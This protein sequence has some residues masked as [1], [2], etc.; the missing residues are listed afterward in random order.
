M[1]VHTPQDHFAELWA[2][3]YRTICPITPPLC[4]LYERSSLNSRLKGGED[5]RGK[6]PGARL[7]DGRWI[8][9][10]YI[11]H[12]TQECELAKWRAMEAGAGIVCT[13]DI[14]GID[15]D[16]LQE[17]HAIIV[18][19]EIKALIGE[20]P[21]RVGRHPKGLYVV[22]VIGP[23]PYQMFEFGAPRADGKRDRVEILANKQFV[24]FGEHPGTRKPY[25]WPKALLPYDDLP[26][27]EASVLAELMQRLAALLPDSGK[28]TTEKTKSAEEVDQNS[29][30]GDPE[31]VRRALAALPNT[32]GMF[33]SRE[34]YLKMGYRLKASLPDNEALAFDL[35]S[36]WSADWEGPEGAV[37]DP[38]IVA[39][40]WRRMKPP[41]RTGAP[42]LYSMAAKA[43]GGDLFIEDWFEE[44]SGENQGIPQDSPKKP[45]DSGELEL[46]VASSLA[47]LPVPPQKWLVK[48]II[49]ADNVTL[50]GG[51]GGT[52]KSLLALQLAEAVALGGTWLAMP[53]EQGV[54]LY[55]SA[56]DEIDELHRR[57]KIIS[58]DMWSLSNL[59]FAPLAG[60]DA[61]LA[62]PAGKEGLLKETALFERLRKTIARLRP[63]VMILDTLADLFGG[64]E[65]KKI[66]ARS[67]V[68]MLRGLA[69][70]FEITVILLFHPSVNGMASGS[71]TSGNVGWSNSVR[72]RLYL[73][74]LKNNDG[75]EN[76]SN[77]RT[78]TVKKANRS[79]AGLVLPLRYDAGKFVQEG[80][81]APVNDVGGQ[82][83]RMFMRLLDQL[84]KEGRP[85]SFK[86][87]A[88]NYAP[89]IFAAHSDSERISKEHFSRAMDRLWKQEM[90]ERAVYK[91]DS[92][93]FDKIARC[94]Q[95]VS[96]TQPEVENKGFFE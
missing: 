77:L 41:F 21:I 83:E 78:L 90:I 35:F 86:T 22:R 20:T 26:K 81:L 64:D 27:V 60:K 42:M 91:R 69:L 70:D 89:K 52:G 88:P 96:E 65:V 59:V 37:N 74:R 40:D 51:D 43:V 4:P 25:H 17:E 85:V 95:D 6:A 79:A 16:T 13:G 18:R 44:P 75:T 12:V 11:S 1:N 61:I 53:V 48:D 62:A 63:S 55:L 50:L 36:E 46:V 23:S 82:A 15:A 47:G 32:S 54:V 10:D 58:A 66:H 5:A 72:S 38:E 68:S 24:A 76:N 31:R 87:T 49:P 30:R 14:R 92:K 56:E 28:L 3:G 9:H 80:A 8:G 67:F 73:D 71:G 29:L 2:L 39:A 34:S 93:E 84:E 19:D 45:G 57:T 33:P 94:K 7:W